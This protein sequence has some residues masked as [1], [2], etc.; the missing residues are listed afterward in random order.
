MVLK[1]FYSDDTKKVPKGLKNSKRF[2]VE[3]P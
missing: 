3:G 1:K 2:L